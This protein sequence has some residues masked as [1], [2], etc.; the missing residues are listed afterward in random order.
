M[1]KSDVTQHDPSILAARQPDNPGYWYLRRLGKSGAACTARSAWS[2][3][4]PTSMPL[5][6]SAQP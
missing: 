5:M 1:A 4:S 2:T 3:W 6:G